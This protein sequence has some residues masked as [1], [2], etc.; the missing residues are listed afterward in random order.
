MDDFL[1]GE[2]EF[3]TNFLPDGALLSAVITAVSYLDADGEPCISYYTNTDSA[4][5]EIIGLLEKLK[6]SILSGTD[7]PED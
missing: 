7:E 1:V 3:I 2:E 4:S 6:Y 5:F